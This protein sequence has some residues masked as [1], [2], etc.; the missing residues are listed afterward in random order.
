MEGTRLGNEKNTAVELGE[1]RE[2]MKRR[3]TSRHPEN[4]REEGKYT[5]TEFSP[6]VDL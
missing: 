6:G 1:R 3:T 5:Y 2:K 4:I